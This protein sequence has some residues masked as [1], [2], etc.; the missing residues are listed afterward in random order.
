MYKQ[1]P[2]PKPGPDEVLINVKYS[3]VCH[4]DLHAVMGDWPVPVKMPLIGGHE[5]AGVV[6][7]RGALVQDVEVGDYAGIKVRKPGELFLTP[8]PPPPPKNRP[9]CGFF[10]NFSSC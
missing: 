1:I 3:G 7:G 4:T 8:E 6:V 9:F 5:G 2:V 10:C